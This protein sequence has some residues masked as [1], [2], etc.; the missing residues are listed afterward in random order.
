MVTRPR[1]GV[2]TARTKGGER[3]K[4]VING[5]VV[6]GTPEEIAKLLELAKSARGPAPVRMPQ[7]VDKTKDM[8][9]VTSADA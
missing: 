8:H 4:T 2:V 1:P 6:E 7:W 5:Q 9:K 3:V